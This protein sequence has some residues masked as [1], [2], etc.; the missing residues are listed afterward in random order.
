MP[1]GLLTLT[2]N[3]PGCQSLKEKRSRLKPLLARLHREFNISAAEMG[4]QDHWSTAILACALVNS[5]LA[6]IHRSLQIIPAW[7]EQHWP[8]VLVTGENLEII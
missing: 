5:D 2:I 7:I 3:I 1:I 4:A 8:D 6:H